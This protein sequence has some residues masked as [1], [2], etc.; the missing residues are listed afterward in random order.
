MVDPS[1][2]WGV[3][4]QGS[5]PQSVAIVVAG[6]AARDGWI[7]ERRSR[8]LGRL[9]DVYELMHTLTENDRHAPL[10]IGAATILKDLDPKACLAVRKTVH[11]GQPS[12]AR[13]VI[14]RWLDAN[15]D[16]H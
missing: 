12:H 3:L 5:L 11:D 4:L 9:L 1:G 6:V 13:D 15:I 8:Q 7:K 14:Q 2:W 10:A 16:K